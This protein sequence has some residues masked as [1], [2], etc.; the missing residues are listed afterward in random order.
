MLYRMKKPSL[1]AV[2]WALIGAL[3]GVVLILIA[4]FLIQGEMQLSVG[5]PAI[6]IALAGAGVGFALGL[7]SGSR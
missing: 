6:W 3:P 4:Q 7:R 5:V 1:R 2:R